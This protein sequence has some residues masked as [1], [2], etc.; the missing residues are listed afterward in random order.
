M[1]EAPRESYTHGDPAAEQGPL[2]CHDARR[3]LPGAGR[4]RS[5][6]R[7]WVGTNESA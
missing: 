2:L 3:S 6:V 5:G 7:Q 4:D 1:D